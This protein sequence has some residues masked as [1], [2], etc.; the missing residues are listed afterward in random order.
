MFSTAT[1]FYVRFLENGERPPDYYHAIYLVERTLWNLVK[2][3]CEKQ[4]F[5]PVRVARIIHVNK[6][7]TPIVVDD[8]VVRDIPEGQDMIADICEATSPDVCGDGGH[9]GPPVEIKFKY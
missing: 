2:K 9:A 3:I 5:D 8:N 1:C 4:K 7:G 6:G